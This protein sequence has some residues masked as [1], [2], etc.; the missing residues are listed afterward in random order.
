MPDRD[1][2]WSFTRDA[3]IAYFSMEIG[4][5]SEI[6]TYSGGLGMLAGDAVRSAA[7]LDIPLVAVTLVSRAGYFRQAVSE[8]GEQQES[9]DIWDPAT[10]AVP[11]KARTCVD[12]E[13]RTVWLTGWL[14]VAECVRGTHV[15]VILIDTDLPENTPEDRQL[16]HYLYGGDNKYRLKQ[17]LLL[18][19]GGVR[20][21]GT[22]GLRI[23][24]HHMNEGHAALL[25]LEL[26]RRTALP[27]RDVR[28]GESV[29]DIP[30][31]RELC[32][33][34]THT[35]VEAGHDRFDYGLVE[36]VA[37]FLID[38]GTLRE[39]GGQDQLNL[40]RLALNMSQYVNGVAESHAETSRHLFPSYPVHAITN[41]VHAST[42]TAHA[43]ADLYDRHVPRW[44]H[45]SRV[46][47]SSTENREPETRNWV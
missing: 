22:L 9:P 34:T 28:A 40:T 20:L 6:P 5:A 23:R 36:S 17:E 27:E 29:Y 4:L 39:L 13:G 37:G 41:G 44:R 32:S 38:E 2:I 31:V 14:Y 16:T 24:H 46:P 19:V 47:S 10:R 35:P 8:D 45:E 33:F 15:P 12:I 25:T 26:L 3:R 30:R 7:D 18:G 11:L 1:V 42:W 21:L 43:F